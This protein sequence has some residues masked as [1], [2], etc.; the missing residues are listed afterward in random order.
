MNFGRRNKV[1]PEFNMASMTDVVFLLLIFFM[2]ASTLAK[3]MDTVDI[4]LPNASGK[5]ENRK[6][7]SVSITK[8]LAYFVD[9]RK[10]RERNLQ[11]E[12]T[13][14]VSD[15][16]EPTVILRSDKSV[17]VE[18]VVKVMDIANKNRIKVILAVKPK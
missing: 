13:G 8:D 2:I 10:I 1:R 9:G 3:Y 4:N 6:T 16:A 15:M 7:V 18:N 17:P 12:I 14:A 5:S 11:R